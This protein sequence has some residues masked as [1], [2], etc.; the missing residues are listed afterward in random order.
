MENVSNEC[1]RE[2]KNTHLYSITFF[3]ENRAV[4][5][6]MRKNY[7]QPGRPQM[8]VWRLR[9]T[10][11]IPTNTLSEYVLLIA[12]PLQ[13][14]LHERASVLRYPCIISLVYLWLIVLPLIFELLPPVVLRE[15]LAVRGGAKPYYF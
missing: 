12:L 3:S 8:T 10:C 1:D 11:R 7:V 13:Q 5:E 15:I 4:Y 14:W 9:I 2:H 6:I